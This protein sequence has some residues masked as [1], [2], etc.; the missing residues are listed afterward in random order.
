MEFRKEVEKMAD[1]MVIDREEAAMYIGRADICMA[2]VPQHLSNMAHEVSLLSSDIRGQKGSEII[3]AYEQYQKEL[4]SV[5]KYISTEFP[6]LNAALIKMVNVA[7]SA[8]GELA[9]GSYRSYPCSIGDSEPY[10]SRK[11]GIR[12]VEGAYNKVSRL[13]DHINEVSS[14]FTDVINEYK[15]LYSICGEYPALGERAHECAEEVRTQAGKISEAT[16]QFSTVLN[17]YI[18]Q[19]VTNEQK[20]DAATAN[21]ISGIKSMSSGMSEKII[22]LPAA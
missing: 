13:N 2:L 6:E 18:D 4:N 5:A 1:S 14:I 8:V 10:T 22:T 15:N 12:S 3:S 11:V 16:N 19:V 21:L 9:E 20:N 17:N 7:G